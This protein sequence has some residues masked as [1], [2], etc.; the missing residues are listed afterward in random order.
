MEQSK[1]RKS[2]RPENSRPDH[3]Y[4][5]LFLISS[6]LFFAAMNLVYAAYRPYFE[7]SS[8]SAFFAVATFFLFSLGVAFL[9]ASAFFYLRTESRRPDA[10]EDNSRI[11]KT[12]GAVVAE[13]ISQKWKNLAVVA[14]IYALVFSFLDGVLI[15][16]P[17]VDFATVYGIS[18]P[19]MVVETCCGPPTYVPVGL[20]YFPAQHF[21]LQLIPASIAI[22]LCISLLVGVNVA[23]M[24]L[25]VEKSRPLKNLQK[26][27][28][29]LGGSIGA[30]FGIFAGCPTCAAAFFL[31]MIA[32]SGAT[33]FSFTISEFQPLILLL[34]IPLLI[35]SIIW[36]SK[37]IETIL[38]G[39][40]IKA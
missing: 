32:G 29:S 39:C 19:Q 28:G 31:S 15:Y 37:C 35:A 22:M 34:S 25:S 18:N 6:V 27:A 14:V 26:N 9:A 7:L 20:V 21:G 10:L 11:K 2:S 17:G 16:Q 12:V 5:R 1:E 38:S 4:A 13:A 40:A 30:V 23:L 8:S 3:R 24:F 36:Q 33:A